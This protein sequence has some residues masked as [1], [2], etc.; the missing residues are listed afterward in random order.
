MYEDDVPALDRG[1]ESESKEESTGP[2]KNPGSNEGIHSEV[3]EQLILGVNIVPKNDA[4]FVAFPGV[5]SRDDDPTRIIFS[6]M[7]WSHYKG[8]GAALNQC[9]FAESTFETPEEKAKS[10]LRLLHS[11]I[12]NWDK[13]QIQDETDAELVDLFDESIH[14]N[15]P[16]KD[17]VEDF[18]AHD[19][20]KVLGSTKEPSS[21]LVVSLSTSDAMA[22][23][24]EA[25][26]MLRH[27]HL[28][29]GSE[30]LLRGRF[31]R[32]AF[33]ERFCWN[34]WMDCVDSGISYRL[35]ERV[36]G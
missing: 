13:V 30:Y 31:G 10:V 28:Y 21:N 8:L 4:D 33:A 35:W 18:N 15:F 5:A 3:I 27:Q 20:L 17:L 25:Q 1:Q 23:F 6:P 9:F 26:S 16:S 34:T 19:P 32:S 14:L 24:I 7:G 29:L 22:R 2:E 11:Y 36:S 12:D